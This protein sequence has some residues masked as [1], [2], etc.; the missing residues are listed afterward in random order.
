MAAAVNWEFSVSINHTEGDRYYLKVE[1]VPAGGILAE[2][3][4]SWAVEDWLDRTR[5]LMNDPLQDILQGR[6]AGIPRPGSL[7]DNAK[8]APNLVDLGQELYD[9]LF[10]GTIRDSWLMAQAI[11][12]HYRSVLRLRIGLRGA[13][14]PRLPWEVMHYWNCPLAATTDITFSRYQI[15]S[16]ASISPRNSSQTPAL[17]LRI[18]M[19][20]AAPGD[21]ESL[22][23]RREAEHLRSELQERTETPLLDL[24]ILEQPGREELT[25]AL[26]HGNYHIFHFSGHSNLGANGGNLFLVNNQNGLT[27]TL[28]GNDL[29][30]LLSNNGVQ[31]VVFN[32]CRGVYTAA[33]EVTTTTGN[34]TQSIINRGIPAVLAMS[35]RI[36]DNVALTLTRLFY[37]NLNQGYPI[38]LS[39]SRARQG[40]I[41]TYGSHQL[42][43]ALPVLYLHPEFDGFLWRTNA[44]VA[45]L[46]QVWALPQE[47]S[48]LFGSELRGLPG[49]ISGVEQGSDRPLILGNLGNLSDLSNLSNLAKTDHADRPDSQHSGDLDN[50][51]LPLIAPEEMQRF[52]RH[53]QETVT[54]DD[55]KSSPKSSQKSH[56]RSSQ[57]PNQKPNSTLPASNYPSGKSLSTEQ[58]PPSSPVP[59]V[60]RSP[61]TLEE[62]PKQ[63]KSTKS[64]KSSPGVGMLWLST[65][66]LLGA[67]TAAGGWWYFQ[68]SQPQPSPEAAKIAPA[69]SLP[70][71][72]VNPQ[73]INLKTAD[74]AT[75][76]TL[77]SQNFKNSNLGAGRLAV[78]ELLDRLAF[79]EAQTTLSAVNPAQTED[80]NV[81]FLR[82]RLA[83][84]AIKT[85]N[86]DFTLEDV[87]KFWDSASKNQPTSV[88]Y[89]NALGFSYYETGD[90]SKAKD[91]WL[92]ALKILEANPGMTAQPQPDPISPRDRFNTYAG[93]ALVFRQLS[94]NL[95]RTER[96]R[97]LVESQNF[98]QQVM[99]EDGLNYQPEIL[100]KNW[101]WTEKAIRDWTALGKF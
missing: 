10:Q 69:V 11:A 101:L 78:E 44:L 27:E 4:V 30:G 36:P 83:W 57:K 2:A 84:Q 85:G 70:V 58:T 68:H 20:I 45:D 18:L 34:L 93:L 12:Q 73:D 46:K 77:G 15:L 49:I 98:Y 95:L 5:Q 75:I 91:A 37:R 86:K 6:D 29:A 47:D 25:Y 51:D 66:V 24:T 22:E 7:P 9:A 90:F 41:S 33:S 40:L 1:N 21:Q 54:F 56:Q 14:L 80:A 64:V 89:Y 97:L 72:T 71:P 52:F 96:N 8:F 63:T 19:V 38:D 26:E 39:L 61:Q 99:K 87:R 59:L 23:L 28:S 67:V 17:P 31:L 62:V 48:G 100:A 50:N 92:A 74:V 82:G 81:N 94:D 43:W 13:T 60:T 88:F 79:K 35:E 32:S 3:Q 65:F 76:V 16:R 53:S 42:Y 55:Q